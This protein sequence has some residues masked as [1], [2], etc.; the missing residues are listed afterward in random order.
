MWQKRIQRVEF[1]EEIVKLQIIISFGELKYY[2][3]VSE[4]DSSVVLGKKREFCQK[5]D[6]HRFSSDWIIKN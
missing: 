6:K 4:G 3:K 5:A 2:E 1:A